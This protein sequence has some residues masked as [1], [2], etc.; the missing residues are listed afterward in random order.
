MLDN[1]M[2]WIRTLDEAGTFLT[3]EEAVRAHDA[4]RANLLRYQALAEDAFAANQSLWK[5]R[6]KTHY[7]SH[8]IE[9]LTESYENPVCL[10]LFSWEDFVGKIKRIASKT[11]RATAHLR[12]V[13]R[14]LLIMSSRWAQRRGCT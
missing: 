9:Q 4:G 13:Q 11:H 5:L 10:D 7:L 2:V 6:P 8:A 12:V 1:L 3:H 14:W